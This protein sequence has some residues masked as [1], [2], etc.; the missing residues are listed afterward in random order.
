MMRLQVRRSL[1][2]GAAL[3]GGLGYVMANPTCTSFVG[4][5]LLRST[6]FCFIFDCQGGVFG[7][8]LDPCAGSG[9]GA[10]TVESVGEN[11]VAPFLNDCPNGP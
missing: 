4:E 6:D 8:T 7:G 11:A 2:K 5:S 3:L 10:Q 1:F 9:S